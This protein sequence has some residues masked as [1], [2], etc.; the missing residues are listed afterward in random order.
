MLTETGV[1]MNDQFTPLDDDD[2]ILLGKDTFKVSRLKELVRKE[3]KH[4]LKQQIYEENSL[5][6]STS[7]LEFISKISV[8]QQKIN[9]TEIKH[10]YITDCQ[11]LRIG[12]FG[13]QTGQLKILV[14][15]SPFAQN[16]NQLYLEFC[17][18][19]PAEH[20]LLVDEIFKIIA[21]K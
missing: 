12:G 3:T 18:E 6:S 7:M 8:G 4:Q 15:I 11:V 10:S 1:E 20:D 5:F 13:W 9:L 21:E 16:Q 17:S 19:E 2:V 14:C